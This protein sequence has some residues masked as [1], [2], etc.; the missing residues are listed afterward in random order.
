M[1][2]WWRSRLRRCN[3]RPRC[4]GRSGSRGSRF[5]FHRRCRRHGALQWGL[6]RSL[7]LGDRLQHISRLGDMRKVNLGANGFGLRARARRPGSGLRL[8]LGTHVCAHLFR[9]VHLDG[10]GMGLLFS[11]SDQREHIQY[12]L[13]LDLQFSGQVIYTNL[14]LHS[15]L[16]PPCCSNPLSLHFNLTV[17][18]PVA[19]IRI[20]SVKK[21]LRSEA[22]YRCVPIRFPVSREEYLF[23]PGALRA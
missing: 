20:H 12:G 19:R 3:C 23:R 8:G 11:D 7:L 4:G 5:S 2:D 13:A 9:L 15:A 10:T 14:L 6:R 18:M 1:R 22:G 17:F 21:L 16:L